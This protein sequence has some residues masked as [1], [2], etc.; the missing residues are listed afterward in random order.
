MYQEQLILILALD[1]DAD[2]LI[3]HWGPLTWMFY[4][5]YLY[6]ALNLSQRALNIDLK[7]DESFVI[8][9]EGNPVTYSAAWK[10]KVYKNQLEAIGAVQRFA[11][12]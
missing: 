4:I 10:L 6:S 3:A 12:Q 8:C 7:D 9:T 2:A 5:L 1:D 11:E